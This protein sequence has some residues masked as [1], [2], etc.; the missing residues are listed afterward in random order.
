MLAL[1]LC[2]G[3]LLQH[4]PVTEKLI[5]TIPLFYPFIT[6]KSD[7]FL[8][9]KMDKRLQQEQKFFCITRPRRCGK[10]IMANMIDVFLKFQMRNSCLITSI[11]RN[12]S[13]TELEVD[14]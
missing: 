5:W 11:Y 14:I 4:A 6:G 10:T 2:C 1:C 8:R 9:R 3:K 7:C 13:N 12:V